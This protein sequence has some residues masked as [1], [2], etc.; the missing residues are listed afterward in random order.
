MYGF[1]GN[2]FDSCTVRVMH[3]QYV[4]SERFRR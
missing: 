4:V 2:N 1:I 3:S